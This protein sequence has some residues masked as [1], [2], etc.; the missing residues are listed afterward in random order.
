MGLKVIKSAVNRGFSR[1]LFSY[2]SKCRAAVDVTLAL[3]KHPCYKCERPAVTVMPLHHWGN[4]DLIFHARGVHLIT[5]EPRWWPWLHRFCNSI[6]PSMIAN[7]VKT[8]SVRS[9]RWQEA[10]STEE[11]QSERKGWRITS[12]LELVKINVNIHILRVDT[13]SI[14]QY[15]SWTGPA[16]LEQSRVSTFARSW[17]VWGVSKIRLCLYRS[18]VCQWEAQHKRVLYNIKQSPCTI[19]CIVALCIL[20]PTGWLLILFNTSFLLNIYK[21]CPLL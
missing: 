20:F 6:C 11:N 17:C 13:L 15:G 4:I 7:L 2:I 14:I 19:S 16:A 21:V 1:P 9:K 8:Q 18:S 12:H 5:Q 3:N 10:E